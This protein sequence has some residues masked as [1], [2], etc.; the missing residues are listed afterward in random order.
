[1][2]ISTM[3]TKDLTKTAELRFKQIRSKMQ[4]MKM[5]A[6]LIN[7][8]P[9]IRYLT[10]FS[11][12]YAHVV[13]LLDE[14]IFLT[15]DLYEQQINI[16]LLPLRGMKTFISRNPF[17]EIASQKLL[18]K[19]KT[20]GIDGDHLMHNT[21]LGIQKLLPKVKCVPAGGIAQEVTVVK[22][23]QEIEHIRKAAQI[24]SKVFDSI[25][26]IIKPGIKETDIATEIVYQGR[27]L[28]AEKESFDIIVVSGE[29]SAMPHGRATD[30]K[31]KKGDMITLD[32]GFYVNGF[33]SDMTRSVMVGKANPEQK[34]VYDTVLKAIETSNAAAKVGMN[35]KKLYA[36]ARNII[37]AEGYGDYFRHSLG[38]GLGIEV[39]EMPRISAMN[40]L[41]K[42]KKNTVI[43]IEPG[44]YL[45]G[46]FGVRIEDDIVITQKGAEILT[47]ATKQLLEL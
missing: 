4:S 9:T 15:N 19:S 35:C 2:A 36:V 41:E 33:A 47:K 17:Q 40:E 38:H 45:P 1:M 29:R 44:I 14:I 43:T 7:H 30:K 22:S 31:I 46:K 28:G 23:E 8:L 42:L 25:V 5:D 13:V 26:K 39:H 37:I 3:M 12:S 11:G 32:F 18:K 20:L 21:V 34:K 27:K 24:A 10:G 16:E 6:L